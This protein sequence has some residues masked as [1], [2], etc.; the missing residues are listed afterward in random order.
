M[1]I[2]ENK[3]NEFE[4]L[5]HY[6]DKKT[7]KLHHTYLTKQNFDLLVQGLGENSLNALSVTQKLD[8]F[9][10]ASFLGHKKSLKPIFDHI[11]KENVREHI[12]GNKFKLKKNERGLD[13]QILEN[14]YRTCI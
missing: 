5:Q 9:L 3:I 7:L 2:P 8:L 4:Y 14:I 12:A 13:K 11:K 6:S 10:A 1:H